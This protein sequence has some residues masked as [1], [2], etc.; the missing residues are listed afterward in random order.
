M[1]KALLSMSPPW[2]ACVLVCAATMPA[3]AAFTNPVV[4]TLSAPGGVIGNATPLTLVNNAVNPS[5]GI[6]VG[7]GTPVGNFMLPNESISFTADNSIIVKIAAGNTSGA[8]LVTGYLGLGAAPAVYSFTNLAVA[9]NFLTGFTGSVAGL[10]SPNVL[11][12]IVTFTSPS[13]LTVRLDNLVLTP[14]PGGGQSDALATLTINM[15]T[16]PI[17]EPSSWALLLA[18]GA[19]VL[20][21]RRVAKARA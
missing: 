1:G 3:Q 8:N 14:V 11:S 2:A 15:L 10:N 6:I 16:T 21:W 19:A 13:T 9:G 17:P 5:V 20:G 7:D 12:S 4:V 18:G